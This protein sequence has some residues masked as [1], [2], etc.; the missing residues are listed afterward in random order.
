MKNFLRALRH[1]WPYRGRLTLSLVCA[2]FAAVFWGLNFTSIYPVLKLLHTG[3]SPQQWVDERITSISIERD[4][5]QNDVDKL[6]EREK[7]LDARPSSKS[8][9]QGLREVASDLVRV[10]SKLEGAQRRLLYLKYASKYIHSW[11]PNDCFQTLC[12]VVGLVF[13]GVIVKCVFEFFQ[14]SLVGSVV[15]LSLF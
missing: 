10:E 7:D 2:I 6:T 15:N 13:A 5:L 3:K 4:A 9:D 8:R 14:E 1:A 11:V 12:L